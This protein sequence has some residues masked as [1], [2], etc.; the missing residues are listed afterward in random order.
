MLNNKLN[1]QFIQNEFNQYKIKLSYYMDTIIIQIQN[2]YLFYESNFKLE[3]IQ[4]H[5]LLVSSLKNNEIIE[6][7]NELINQKN[8]KIEENENDLKFILI[9]TLPNYPNA[10]L[11][12]NKKNIISNEI[13][14]KLINEIKEVKDDNNKLRNRIELIET[15]NE[16]L[17]KRID[18]IEK[19]N[20]K[21]KNLKAIEKKIKILEGFH[22][23]K[24]KYKVKL[25]KCDLH[26]INSIKSH[27]NFINSVSTFPSGNII[28]VSADKS[29]KIYDIHLNEL[30]NI[31]KAHNEGIAYVEIKDENN[32]IT[33]S[34]DIN[35]KLNMKLK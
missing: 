4:N 34:K 8:I 16:N 29:I 23:T 30:Q 25:K 1:N 35:I 2:D 9:S 5:K 20:N 27:N 10:E 6:F 12:L 32:F 22:F 3:N 15:K 13:I 31:Q 14:E 17:N 24:N 19:E 26:N 28:S 33:C 7:I 21:R 18:L 11:I